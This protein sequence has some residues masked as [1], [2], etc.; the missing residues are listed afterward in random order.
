MKK[1]TDVVKQLEN[2]KYTKN[3]APL[4]ISSIVVTLVAICVVVWFMLASLAPATIAHFA[5]GI[6]WNSYAFILYEKD[7]ELNKDINSL[8]MAL[9]I[10][11][12]LNNDDKVIELYEKFINNSEYSNFIAYVN[13][14]NLKLDIDPQLK[15][16]MLDEDNYL[17]NRYIQSLINK[18]EDKKAWDF[19]MSESLDA[20]PE[21]NEFGN[22]LFANFC[23]DGVVDRFY[24]NFRVVGD[25]GDM[26]VIDMYNYM[27]AV[28]ELFLD[29]FQNQQS[30]TYAWAMGN[31]VLQVGANVLTL[32]EKIGIEDVVE[33]TQTIMDNVNQKFKLMSVE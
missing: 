3:Y 24:N 15:S 9:N 29:N 2:K 18:N 8:Y 25:S 22:Y 31:R 13:E 12:K 5:Y 14:G 7:Y 27:V 33:I 28:N 17:K 6:N 11:I 21:Y 23:K 19:A 20:T 16:T 1:E 30:Q 32:C 4:I 10:S 26:L